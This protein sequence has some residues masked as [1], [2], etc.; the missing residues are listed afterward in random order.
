M[1]TRREH[2]QKRAALVI[3][4]DARAVV[5]DYVDRATLRLDHDGRWASLR[6]E[7]GRWRRT[8]DGRVL[9]P[10]AGGGYRAASA[11]QAAN[12]HELAVALAAELAAVWAAMPL[13]NVG[14]VGDG[15]LARDTLKLAQGW[16]AE[17]LTA[18]VA[19]FAAAWP[20]PI[21]ILPPHRYADLVLTPAT[22]CPNHACTF[23]AFERGQPFVVL[24]RARFAEH[25]DRA[26]TFLGRSA[27]ARDG[28]FLSSGSALSLPNRILAPCLQRIQA[29][30]G[31]QKRGIA[32]FLDPDR[33]PRRI[34]TDW[35]E[36]TALGLRDATLG[37]ETGEPALRAQVGKA[38]TLAAFRAAVRALKGAGM[39]V[40][41]T[42][43]G[44]L[45][46]ARWQAKHVSAT[47]RE[48]AAMELG[49]TDTV[50]VSPLDPGEGALGAT[51]T[52]PNRLD[53][54]AASA[55]LRAALKPRTDA[56]VAAYRV[57]RFAWFA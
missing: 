39:K 19:E 45:G 14:L 13:G 53:P 55:E 17:R 27:A 49:R 7:A 24:D 30:L 5:F 2:N 54:H 10:Q 15:A 3:R 20:A 31:P 43:I 47:V 42:V 8:V 36:L 9:A 28:V 38:G 32:A 52:D 56:K 48:V 6:T 1:C 33:A 50:Y 37:L 18:Q 26:L 57:E 46:G 11:A 41:M 22:G 23:C 40:H 44:G 4:G 51:K 25:I 16:S 35:A 34:G 12:V 29:A 21:T